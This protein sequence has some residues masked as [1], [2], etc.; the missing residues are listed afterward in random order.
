MVQAGAMAP[1]TAQVGDLPMAQVG[2]LPT[3]LVTAL[4]GAPVIP[5]RPLLLQFVNN[6]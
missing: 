6:M 5:L 3:V 2:D 1:V 4:D